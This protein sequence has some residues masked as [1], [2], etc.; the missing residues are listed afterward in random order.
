MRQPNADSPALGNTNCNDDSHT[1]S[2]GHSDLH[3]DGNGNCNADSNTFGNA[4]LHARRYARPME[5]GQSIPD[6]G[7]ALRL[8]ADRHALLCVRWSVQWHA[9]A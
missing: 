5:H 2:Y 1:Y 7:R 6:N 8:C 3:T 9:C 4:N